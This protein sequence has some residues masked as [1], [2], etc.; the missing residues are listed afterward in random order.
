ME[1]F[2]KL[3]K[4]PALP[5]PATVAGPIALVKQ[6]LF[7]SPL[8]GLVSVIGIAL[9]LYLIGRLL[10]WAVFN[11]VWHGDSR[12]ACTDANG[13]LLPGACWPFIGH[14]LGQFIYGFYPLAQRWR[15][16]LAAAL[17]VVSVLLFLKTQ[18]RWFVAALYPVLAYILL[19]GGVFALPEVKTSNWGGL[20]LTVVVALVGIVGSLPLGILLA[21]GRR[22]TLPLL[23]WLAIG[24]IELVRAVPL[25]TVLFMASVMLPLF[26]PPGVNFDK[27]LRALI[28]MALFSA[29]YMAEVVR[30]GLQ[31]I[32]K[33]QYEAAS[34]LGLGYWRTMRLVVLPQ[35][36]RIA[37]PGIVNTFIGL[38][39]DTTLV[40]AIGL[41]DL[42]GIVSA[43]S[44][45]SHWL[46]FTTEGYVFIA[47][48]FWILCF[49]MSRYSAHLERRLEGGRQ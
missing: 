39:K 4:H 16:D 42:I 17:L 7:Y 32:P 33:G 36:L 29:A 12:A 44:A 18:A 14:R 5:P 48:I 11:A 22:S 20:L 19:Y 8:A 26:L 28:G 1:A 31:A 24:F 25:I 3:D 21:L 2:V 27:L 40:A 47:L 46:G 6:R 34:S 45:D 43:A 23:R 15:V 37:I 10:G 9:G 30:G 41:F 38:A 35:A 49:G 13:A